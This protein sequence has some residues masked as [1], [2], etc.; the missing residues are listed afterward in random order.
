MKATDTRPL[1][2]TGLEVTILGLGGAPLGDLYERIPEDRA[3]ATIAHAYD[4]GVRLF[5]TAP[6]Y[7]HGLSEHRFGHLLRQKP[8]DQFV[9]ST[10]VGRHLAPQDP[11]SL[12]RGQWAGG[13]NMRLVPDY[14]YDGAMRAF[15]QSLQRLGLHRIDIIHI[16]DVDVWNWGSEEAFQQRFREA[17]EGAYRAIHDLRAQGVV[18]AIGVGV[19]EVK[20][21]LQFAAAG[22]FDTFM[23]AGRYTLLEQE[24]LD[25]LLPLCERRGIGILTAGPYNSGILATGPV[26]GAKYNY[27]PAPPEI[28]ERVRRIEAVCQRHGVKLPAAAVQF[29]LAHPAVA[30][31][32]PGAVRPEEVDA[33]LRLIETP[34]PAALWAE[35]KHERLLREDAPTP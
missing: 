2:K 9:L 26:P 18:R 3:I 17:M 35:L 25:E 29:P 24:P 8:R 10:K 33:N 22:D 23:L 14:S 32:V 13:L 12:D 28:L 21:M 30:A 20:P 11:G 4:H 34:I 1:G 19:N 15:E 31:M 16:H 5:D 27:K 6:L 7:G